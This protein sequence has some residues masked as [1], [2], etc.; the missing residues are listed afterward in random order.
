[1]S[2]ATA[3]KWANVVLVLLS[4]MTLAS[5][6]CADDLQTSVV[7][8][9]SQAGPEINP[10]LYGQ[11]I[12]HMGRCIHDGIWAEMLHDRKF[13]LEPGKMWE[14]SGGESAD[15]D[16]AHDTAGAYC[17]DHCLAIWVRDAADG[18]C[19]ISQAGLGLI[20]GKEYVGYVLL[21]HVAPPAPV[22]VRLAWGADPGA[23]AETVLDNV[24]TEYEKFSFRF[25]AGASTD[26]A[27]LSLTMDQPGYVWVACLSLMP[28]DA[29]RGMRADTL[30]LL[31]RLNAPIY[32]WPG[33][34]FVSGYHWKDGLGPR[35]R[36]PPRW[37]RA[38]QGVED[39]DFGIDEFLDFCREIRTEPLIVVNTGLGSVTEA[40]QEME[41]VNGSTE[42]YWGARRARAGHPEP[43]G[44]VWW[45][46][47]NE[48][49]GDWQ[50]GNVPVERYALRNNAFVQAMKKVDPQIRTVAVG[51]PGRW[52]DAMIPRCADFIDVLSGHHYTERRMRV[53]FSPED[54]RQY[55]ENFLP[56]SGSV[57]AG[58]KN[59]I[60]DLRLRQ[61]GSNP[62]ID[63]IRLAIDEWGIVREWN[64][65]PDGPGVGIY[66]VYYPLGDG[67]ANAR[68][69]HELIRAADVVEIGQWAQA[70]N[71]IGA[72]K[73]SKTHASMG[74]VGHFLALYRAQ[75]AGRVLPVT[76]E[77]Q[78]P[79]DV[80][81]SFDDKDK[82]LSLGLINYSPQHEV[83][84]SL[85]L[86]G[87]GDD[88]AVRAW[89]I[90][91]PSLSAIN[92]PGQPEQVTTT[93]LSLT[94][95]P[96]TPLVLP[97]HSI[98]VLKLK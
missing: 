62:A 36:R 97:R 49:F 69:L 17:G 74:P 22:T 61:D 12:E 15:F 6:V 11:F 75:V 23:A 44:V 51:A 16:V 93:E 4:C 76:V 94:M 90:D 27:R 39:N 32:R 95:P 77:P 82:S 85:E 71:V 65:A 26:Q 56:Y 3:G 84:L 29:V 67:I 18:A 10:Y 57:A 86:K 35:D 98:T 28:A 53:P 1:M 30:E 78:V 68:A 5:A 43:Y 80:V 72:I 2:A 55:E 40:V 59:I 20:E 47:G 66:E 48:M 54:E 58:V 37:E 7:V 41:Y 64:P 9:T 87:M 73:T 79:L 52:N 42:T 45:G 14:K 21:R 34:N 91:G 70:V 50:L 13:L 46:I 24:G 8:D 83:T 88:P 96:G 19:G 31:K 89:R 33:G 92:V 63:R 38:W 60:D 25:R 81:A